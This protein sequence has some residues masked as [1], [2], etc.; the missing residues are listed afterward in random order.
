M[1]NF[2]AANQERDE[3]S[4]QEIGDLSCKIVRG[5]NNAITTKTSF[6]DIIRAVY[7][8]DIFEMKDTSIKL[9]TRDDYRLQDVS[10]VNLN[11]PA[12][13]RESC[14]QACLNYE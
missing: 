4:F 2:F 9:K 12:Y 14:K 5:C 7:V 10:T 3:I 8:N 1:L 13:V 6:D 11:M